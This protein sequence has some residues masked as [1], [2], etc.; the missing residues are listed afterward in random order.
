MNLFKRSNGFYYIKFVDSE[1]IER[2]VSTN[3]SK[4]SEALKYLTYYKSEAN[5]PK[6]F[7]RSILSLKEKYLE[8]V[9]QKFS[10]KYHSIMENSL[11]RFI[12]Y[13]GN[14][15][16]KNITK[17]DFEKFILQRISKTLHGANLDYRNIRTFL[18]WCIENNYLEVNQITKVKFPKIPE[19]QNIYL[20][21]EQFETILTKESS[22]I[23]KDIYQFAINSGLRLSEIIN[24]RLSW[25]DL[26]DRTITI[27][28]DESFRTKNN[29][30]RVIPL[31]DKMIEIIQRHLP[32][33]LNLFEDSYLFNKHSI[34]FNP[35]FISKRFKKAVRTAYGKD[36][37]IHFHNLRGSFGS[38]L[39]RKGTPSYLVMKVLGHSNLSVTEKNYLSLNIDD[40]RKAV[41]LIG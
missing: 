36:S 30:I 9:S 16:I 19:K 5:K 23:L 37:K 3:C 8:F 39:I 17:S 2:R 12:G 35:G 24:C 22:P 29:K 1:G 27:K 21:K 28:N 14:I 40:L 33:I 20:S 25:I 32:K 31:N 4:K 10:R 38:E 34:K 11:T 6:L 15:P 13:S 7:H 18:N 41:N 26:Q